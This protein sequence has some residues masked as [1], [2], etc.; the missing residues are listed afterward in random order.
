MHC[1]FEKK[2][3]TMSFLMSLGKRR[4]EKVRVRMAPASEASGV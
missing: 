4:V 2:S 1:H 3:E